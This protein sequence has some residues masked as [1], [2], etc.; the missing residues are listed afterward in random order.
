M[1]KGMDR[2]K[3]DKKKPT[4]TLEEKRAA[5]KAKRES[6]GWLPGV[7]PAYPGDGLAVHT[8][9]PRRPPRKKSWILAAI[10]SRQRWR[11]SRAAQAMCGVR[12]KFGNARIEQGIAVD[13]RF[14]R[15]HVDPRAPPTAPP[16]APC[17]SAWPSTN[18]PRAV[19]I[20]TASGFI[21]ASSRAPIMP[22]VDGVSG[23][24]NETTSAV[25]SS[26]GERRSRPGSRA[27]CPGRLPT[28]TRMPNASAALA[29]AR[30]NL[31]EADHA[32]RAAGELAD[33]MREHGALLAPHPRPVGRPDARIRISA[34]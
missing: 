17:A 34:E 30:P 8:T 24:C 9:R 32:Q 25:A 5:K 7:A 26:S 3:E 31:P 16:S 18:A 22:R 23:Q 2:K 12:I 4:K 33:G 20:S 19:L 13:R 11:A 6:K 29:T 28:I 15:Q 10:S 14:L 21:S 1:G 27:A